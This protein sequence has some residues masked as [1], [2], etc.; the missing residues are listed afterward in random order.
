[1]SR[2][3]GNKRMKEGRRTQVC[4]IQDPA[5]SFPLNALIGDHAQY[6]HVH[7]KEGNVWAYGG[8]EHVNVLHNPINKHPAN[9]TALVI[10][11]S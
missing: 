9:I 3:G 5:R 10:H 4:R 11:S 8:S 2:E 6:L 1:M 7:G